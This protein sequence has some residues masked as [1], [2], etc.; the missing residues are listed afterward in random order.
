MA[1]VVR[2][3]LIGLGC[4]LGYYAGML[5]VLA[6]LRAAFHFSGELFR[7]LLHAVA[8][9]SVFVLLYAVDTWYAAILVAQSFAALVYG[10]IR[11]VERFLWTMSFLEERRAGEIRSSLLLAFAMMSILIAVFWGWLGEEWKYVVVVAVLA[12]GV[13]DGAAALVG[14][15]FGRRRIRH[16]LVEGTK[17]LEGTAAMAATAGL[18]IL[19]SLLVFTSFPWFVCLAV[20]ALVAPLAAAVELFSRR[21][22][23]TFTVPLATAAATFALISLIGYWGGIR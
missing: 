1:A 3:G 17:T 11:L 20:T 5:A 21:G 18:S 7:K 19:G 22:S 23:D 9:T 2:E 10:L 13:G 16:R 4:F 14:K 12:W 15:A 6:V 8:F